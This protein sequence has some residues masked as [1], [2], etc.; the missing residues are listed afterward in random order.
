MILV[1]L[2]LLMLFLLLLLVQLPLLLLLLQLPCT[3]HIHFHW[4]CWTQRKKDEIARAILKSIARER[5]SAWSK[6]IF[7]IINTN[8]SIWS[9]SPPPSLHRALHT[10]V[11][12]CI[13]INGLA[14]RLHNSSVFVERW[15]GRSGRHAR[16]WHFTLEIRHFDAC[17][18]K[19]RI[20]YSISMI[21]NKHRAERK[22]GKRWKWH[23]MIYWNSANQLGVCKEHRNGLACTFLR[24]L[25]VRNDMMLNSL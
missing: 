16:K 8:I 13:L 21:T 7:H 10:V 9:P 24:F 14:R 4:N 2:P 5:G 18:C 23:A 12:L 19:T 17:L 15:V 20:S 25:G 3:M 11:E 22:R 1:L 6:H